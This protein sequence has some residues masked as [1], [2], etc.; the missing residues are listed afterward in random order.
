MTVENDADWEE[1]V[2]RE[3]IFPVGLLR[4]EGTAVNHV[5]ERINIAC[6][7]ATCCVRA[8]SA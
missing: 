5:A 8:N 6:A 7:V 4:W 2:V 1:L 3:W